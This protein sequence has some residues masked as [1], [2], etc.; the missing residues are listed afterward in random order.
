ME[1]P[2]ALAVLPCGK[3]LR[4]YI[5]RGPLQSVLKH[6]GYMLLAND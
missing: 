2:I 1:L 6:V 5:C 3:W 4:A